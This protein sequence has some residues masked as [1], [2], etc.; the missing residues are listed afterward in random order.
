MD[1]GVQQDSDADPAVEAQHVLAAASNHDLKSLRTLLRTASASVQD[2]ENGYTPLHAAIAGADPAKTTSQPNGVADDGNV[3]GEAENQE[4]DNEEA[5]S[6]VK[7]LLQNGAI[8]NDLDKYDETPGCLALR[9]GLTDLYN[10][11]VD[12]GVRAE[13][14]LSRLEEYEQLKDNSSNEDPDTEVEA[15]TDVA[16]A[17]TPPPSDSTAPIEESTTKTTTTIALTQDPQ[18]NQP[19]YLTSPLSFHP[20]CILDASSNSIMMTWES[21]LMTLTATLLAPTTG[22]RILNIGHGMGIIDSEFQS[23]N[24][25]THHIIEAHPSI[26]ARMRERGWYEKPNVVIHE[27]RWQDVL[28]RLIESE[29]GKEAQMFDAVYFDTFAESYSALRTFFQ[30]FVIGLLDDGGTWG[31]FNGLGADRQVCYDV[32]AKVV[33][34]DLFEAGFEVQWTAVEVSDLE[35][36]GE[37]EGVRRAYWRARE[38][39][40]PV[41]Q[42]MG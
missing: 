31:F 32:Y 38:Y 10:L 21:H 42:F 27:G 12:A 24:P 22:L 8:W 20:T 19:T 2:P 39:R 40:L 30:D 13:I 29:E 36:R 5:I 1:A 3:E 41:C 26:L 4:S 23:T 16:S 9:L 25:S 6:T 17:S 11:I 34:L 7:L 14:L 35:G 37:W 15:P 18:P 33:E 28:P